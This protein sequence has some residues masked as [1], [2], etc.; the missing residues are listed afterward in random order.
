MKNYMYEVYENNL[1]RFVLKEHP[2]QNILYIGDHKEA[3]VL[4]Q[5]FE[6]GKGFQGFTPLFIMKSGYE[7]HS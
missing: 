1:K 7:N 6:S 5:V 2:S 3:N 4:K